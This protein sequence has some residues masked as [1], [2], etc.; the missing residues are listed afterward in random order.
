MEL[1]YYSLRGDFKGILHFV[2]KSLIVVIETQLIPAEEALNLENIT[3]VRDTRE[4]QE[5]LTLVANILENDGRMR[6]R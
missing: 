4:L 2:P 3:H 5:R 1:V 6:E